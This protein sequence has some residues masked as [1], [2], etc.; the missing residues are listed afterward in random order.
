MAILQ[1]NA[2]VLATRNADKV[3]EIKEFMNDLDFEFLDFSGFPDVPEVVED[4]ETFSDNAIKKATAIYRATGISA[5]ADD[6]GLEVDYLNGA[7]GVRSSRFAG[8]NATYAENNA[9][10]LKK[11]DAVPPHRRTARFRCVMAFVGQ[12]GTQ[13]VEGVCEGIILNELKGSKGF[14]YDPLF[15]V[16][17]YGMT[18]AEMDLVLKNRI[19]HR[20]MA[21]SKMRDVLRHR[22]G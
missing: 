6:S 2:I 3:I 19:S 5:L 16:P 14:G 10:L 1:R 8:E 15:Y 11:L 7:P 21:L 20:G 22:S 17:E 13:T 9:L 12:S 4:G 18:F